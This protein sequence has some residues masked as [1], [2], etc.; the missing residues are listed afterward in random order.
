[1]S[2]TLLNAGHPH[3][4]SANPGLPWNADLIKRYL[5]NWDWSWLS[6]NPDLPWTEQIVSDFQDNWDWTELSKNPALPWTKNFVVQYAAKLDFSLLSE[7]LSIPWNLDILKTF[8][9]KWNPRGL[10]ANSLIIESLSMRSWVLERYGKEAFSKGDLVLALGQNSHDVGYLNKVTKTTHLENEQSSKFATSQVCATAFSNI[11][12]LQLRALLNKTEPNSKEAVSEDYFQ[13]AEFWK[14]E[15][16]QT[17]TR[18]FAQQYN[19]YYAGCVRST[20]LRSAQLGHREAQY[21]LAEYYLLAGG[22]KTLPI[23]RELA[24][25]STDQDCLRRAIEWHRKAAKQGHPDAQA[26]LWK[27]FYFGRDVS[28]DKEE[29]LVWLKRLAEKELQNEQTSQRLGYFNFQLGAH[30]YL[31]RDFDTARESI[32]QSSDLGYVDA[33]VLLGKMHLEGR[34]VEKNHIRGLDLL[35]RAAKHDHFIALRCLGALYESVFSHL[36]MTTE[37]RGVSQNLL[38]KKHEKYN[39]PRDQLSVEYILQKDGTFAGA[40][41]NFEFR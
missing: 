4:L 28:Q 25:I 7:N 38:E 16:Y 12:A 34:G 41:L 23:F 6:S 30:Y 17:H 1:M 35:H 27:S 8:A 22:F 3:G 20:Y 37:A 9:E 13:C 5:D 21:K 29:A 31:E 15:R 24:S 10:I 40:V 14:N 19:F 11:S 39:I 2:T 33:T 26:F 32:R 36:N 18:H